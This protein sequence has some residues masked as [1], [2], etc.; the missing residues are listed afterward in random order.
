MTPAGDVASLLPHAG[1]ARLVESVL[2]LRPEGIDCA[3]RIA[4]AHALVR[5][6]AAPAFVGLE[7]AAQAAALFEALRRRE[8]GEAG[9]PRV[10]LLVSLKDVRIER[11]ELPAGELLVAS[12]RSA[13][14]AGALSLYE[15]E[16]R[17][18]G[19]RV[20]GGTLGVFLRGAA[21]AAPGAL[22]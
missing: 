14:G 12:I 2:E 3:G 4:R 15:A 6:G 16:V 13:G 10:G 7:L 20:L 1:V 17:L 21:S 11:A 22:P 5:G 9:E 19:E 18:S 8:R